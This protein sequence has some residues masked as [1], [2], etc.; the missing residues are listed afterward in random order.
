MDAEDTWELT[1]RVRRVGK[2]AWLVRPRHLRPFTPTHLEQ[3][4]TTTSCF[5]SQGKH[6][7]KFVLLI[8]LRP[9][10]VSRD[11]TPIIR[12]RPKLS[13][14]DLHIVFIA[15]RTERELC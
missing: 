14:A 3:H 11:A 7:S 8:N 15:D 5:R 4:R 9:L 6:I 10:L 13:K 1:F 12:F 2:T